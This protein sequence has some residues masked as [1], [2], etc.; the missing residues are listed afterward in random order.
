MCFAG[1][2]VVFGH[3]F[4]CAKQT[5]YYIWYSLV[6]CNL[7]CRVGTTAQTLDILRYAFHH[8]QTHLVEFG[9]N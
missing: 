3:R 5:K 2:Q 4:A 7:M 8:F 9:Y 6:C 1:I